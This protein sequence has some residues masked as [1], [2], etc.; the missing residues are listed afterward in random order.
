[1]FVLNITVNGIV[2]NDTVHRVSKSVANQVDMNVI[3]ALVSLWCYHL[4]L[5]M[6]KPTI[7]VSDQVR[8]KPACTVTEETQNLESLGISRGGNV[9]SV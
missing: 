1:M 6:R 8:H 4:S 9:L 2:H 3:V 7:W 5:C